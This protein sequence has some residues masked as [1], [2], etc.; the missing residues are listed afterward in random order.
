MNT[1]HAPSLNADNLPW[2]NTNK[3]IDLEDLRGRL[4]ILD[5]WTYCCINCLQI[6]PTLKRVEN[7]FP[8]SLT[9]IGVHSPKFPGEKISDNVEKAIARHEIDHPVVH[10]S[11]MGIWKQYTVHSW[12]TLVF[13]SPDGYVL[14]QLPGEPEP[15]MLINTVTSLV[16]DYK[17]KGTLTNNKFSF[18]KNMDEDEYSTLRFPGKIVYSSNDKLFAIADANHHQIV[19]ADLS[20]NIIHRIGNG[21][22]GKTDGGFNT[23]QFHLPQGL[24]VYD[25]SIWVADTA[26]H[27]IR[28]IDITNQNVETVAGTGKQGR[29]LKGSGMG[30]NV[31]I[32][33]PW[34]TEIFEGKLYFA[35]A[36]SHQIGVLDI[37]SGIISNFAGNGNE[38]LIDGPR[39]SASFAQPSGLTIG[40]GKLFLADSETSAIRSIN[41]DRVGQTT[42]YIGKGLFDFGDKDGNGASAELQHPLGVH[43]IDGALFIADSYNHK[44]R[45]LD[46]S[47][48]DVHTVEASANIVCTDKSCTRIWEPAGMIELDMCLYVSD[49]NNHRILKIDLETETTEIFI[50]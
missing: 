42:T 30:Q 47:N 23:A 4:V 27:L 29:V 8:D 9:V 20:G 40:D 12:P 26:N 19:V 1:V 2:F 15:E 37:E 43:Y 5:F 14:G 16:E 18:I 46:L 50:G 32:S 44:I 10:D 28:K 45:V 17:K 25:G 3:P 41:L 6:I 7:L 13:I 22:P 38:A 21:E 35:N 48:L 39:L 11:E 31:A 34:D 24:C 33:S 36:G 49:T